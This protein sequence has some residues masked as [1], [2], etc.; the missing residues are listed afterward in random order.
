MIKVIPKVE[1]LGYVI[2][3]TIRKEDFFIKSLHVVKENAAPVF[4]PSMGV[5]KYCYFTHYLLLYNIS[6]KM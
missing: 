4:D 5:S 6:A 3:N 2:L 1:D